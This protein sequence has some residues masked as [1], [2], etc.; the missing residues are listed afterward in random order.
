MRRIFTIAIEFV[1]RIRI[2]QNLEMGLS[3]LQ[4]ITIAEKFVYLK[5]A[6]SLRIFK[7][8]TSSTRENGKNKSN[9]TGIWF[10]QCIDN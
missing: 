1:E 4:G 3:N 7:N 9:K 8:G 2:M 6:E 10:S 5:E